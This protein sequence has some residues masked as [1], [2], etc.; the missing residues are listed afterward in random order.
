MKKRTLIIRLIIFLVLLV[1]LN[2]ASYTIFFRIDFSADKSFT[3]SRAT[4]TILSN[5]DEKVVID[6]YFSEDLPTQ[7][8]KSR[9]DYEDI[10]VEY[11]NRGG[12]NISFSFIN[13]NES[14]ASETLA[15]TEGISPVWLMYPSATR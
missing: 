12:G 8:I 10:L 1:L 15:Q 14:E 4:K 6:S 7:L 5:L 3:L 2:M 11:K 9:K 13:P